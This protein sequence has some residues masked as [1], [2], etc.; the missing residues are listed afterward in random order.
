M[1]RVG[2]EP[3]IPAFERAKTVHAL[4]RAVTVISASSWRSAYLSTKTTL[5]FL[6]TVP[7]EKMRNVHILVRKP[8]CK[9]LLRRPEHRCEENI[10]VNFKVVGCD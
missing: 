3:T 4:D 7:V 6:F 5:P 2:F 9:R 8:K 1:P 10:K